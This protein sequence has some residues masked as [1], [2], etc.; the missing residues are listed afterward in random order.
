MDDEE[1]TWPYKGSGKE[2]AEGEDV[3]ARL[4][5]A[6]SESNRTSCEQPSPPFIQ[7]EALA[8]RVERRRVLQIYLSE[9][10]KWGKA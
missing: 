4:P 10:W 7:K 5:A 6:G 1:V 3:T 8:R 9:H 2:W